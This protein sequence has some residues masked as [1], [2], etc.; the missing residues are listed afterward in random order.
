[1]KKLSLILLT[2]AVLVSPLNNV[3]C[4]FQNESVYINDF[5]TKKYNIILDGSNGEYSSNELTISNNNILKIN[6]NKLKYF[7]ILIINIE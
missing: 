7:K 5:N 1:M 2:L 6:I 4:Y 3:L